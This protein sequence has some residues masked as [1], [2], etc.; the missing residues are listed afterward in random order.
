MPV[1]LYLMHAVTVAVAGFWLLSALPAVAQTTAA[2]IPRIADG[3]PDLN[4]IWQVLNTA[5]WNLEPHAASQGTVETLGAIGA[6]AP[7]IGV[8]EGGQIPYLPTAAAQRDENFRNRRTEDPEA[9][10]F[11]PGV[12]RATYMP[13][14]FQIFQ[15]DTDL[16]VSYQYA[17]AVR[18]IFMQDHVEAPVDSWMGWSN[19]RWEGDT[20]IVD[21]AGLNGQTW[22]DRS[23]NFG[24]VRLRVV[25]R[26]TLVGPNHIRYEATLEDPDVYSRPWTI[27][28]PL[29]RRI[30]PNI[31]LL[32]FKCVP[33]AE[34]MMYGHLRKPGTGSSQDGESDD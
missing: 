32:E 27:S 25:E 2:E 1:R 24:S 3:R 31:R 15:T 12:P 14:P 8:I 21:V 4:G 28:M 29:Y 13:H 34:E 6:V 10:C 19:G 16:F 5:N 22:L 9:K 7:G 20:L 23:G 26:Y 33:F 11:R 18:T 17:G 30:E